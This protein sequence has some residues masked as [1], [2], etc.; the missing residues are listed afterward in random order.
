MIDYKKIYETIGELTPIKADCG[1]LCN[2]AC[3]V[4][5]LDTGMYLYPNEEKIYRNGVNFAR[6]FKSEFLY[7]FE[8]KSKETYILIC[9][10]TCDRELRPLACRIFPFIPYMDSEGEVEIIVDPR[11]ES[12][13]PLAS[14]ADE[15]EFDDEF[16]DRVAESF[17]LGIEDDEFVAFVKAQS[18]LI[19]EYE[20]N[21]FI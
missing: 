18:K 20:E 7:Y 16:I 11:A 5:D 21:A 9:N 17:S 8:G 3:C 13:C 4:G 6:I 2:K 14:C 19:D 10:G 15:V 1:T 12:M